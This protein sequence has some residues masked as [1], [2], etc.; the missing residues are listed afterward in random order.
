[1]V[2]LSN[3]YILTEK[4]TDTSYSA[5]EIYNDIKLLDD[6]LEYGDVYEGL[7]Q[8]WEYPDGKIYQVEADREVEEKNYYS[9]PGSGL[10][11][12]RLRE[13]G[14]DKEKAEKAYRMLNKE[15]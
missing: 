14:I 1:M 2:Q 6:D 13:I 5:T 12:P 9:L 15:R 3:I 10:W 8:V 11:A 7:Y 4:N